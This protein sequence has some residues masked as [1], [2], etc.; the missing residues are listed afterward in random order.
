MV[1]HIKSN[2]KISCLKCNIKRVGNIT[3]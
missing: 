1:G 3:C 2:V